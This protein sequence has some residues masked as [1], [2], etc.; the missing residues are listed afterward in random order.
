MFTHAEYHTPNHV[1]L[2]DAQ[3]QLESTTRSD[4]WRIKSRIGSDCHLN[5]GYYYENAWDKG[6]LASRET[7]GWGTTCRKAQRAAAETFYYSNA[8]MQH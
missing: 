5:N 1:V 7:A 8:S 2:N 4:N 3:E 6:H